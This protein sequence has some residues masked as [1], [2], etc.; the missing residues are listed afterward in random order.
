MLI[1]ILIEKKC[2]RFII[3]AFAIIL[4]G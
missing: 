1:K 2:M 3:D 4:S